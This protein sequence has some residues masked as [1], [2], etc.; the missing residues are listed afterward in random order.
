[1]TLLLLKIITNS[2][3]ITKKLLNLKAGPLYFRQ[4]SLTLVYTSLYFLDKLF[5]EV[6]T[7]SRPSK[8]EFVAKKA[9]LQWMFTYDPNTFLS[10]PAEYWSEFVEHF[11]RCIVNFCEQNH[12]SK[13][14][15]VP[16]LIYTES[17][18]NSQY[19]LDQESD[20]FSLIRLLLASFAVSLKFWGDSTTCVCL[21][22]FANLALNHGISLKDLCL[23]EIKFLQGI[24]YSLLLSKKK[25]AEF[26]RNSLN[27]S[28]S[29]YLHGIIGDSMKI[30]ESCELGFS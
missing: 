23:M 3:E 26:K 25:I 14:M 10:F 7:M 19:H 13:K 5:Y 24:D 2:G 27:A 1:M 12:S 28:V 21:E 11:L 4:N 8:S 22:A 29:P 6:S 18:L 9:I 16:A 15:I 30:E 17:Y 20:T